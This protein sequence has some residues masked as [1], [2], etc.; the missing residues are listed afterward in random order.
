MRTGQRAWVEDT[1]H[2]FNRIVTASVPQV[3]VAWSPLTVVMVPSMRTVP[4]ALPGAK[5]CRWA[6]NIRGVDMEVIL[7]VI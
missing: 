2:R 1:S 4:V 6:G 5:A 7:V 3:R